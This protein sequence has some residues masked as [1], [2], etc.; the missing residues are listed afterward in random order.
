MLKFGLSY[1]RS[2][3]HVYDGVAYFDYILNDTIGSIKGFFQVL[4]R[5]AVFSWN[6]QNK[7]GQHNILMREIYKTL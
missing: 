7:V 6:R 5:H 1:T 2:F 3:S 4:S